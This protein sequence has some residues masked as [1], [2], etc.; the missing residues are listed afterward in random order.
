MLTRLLSFGDVSALAAAPPVPAVVPDL[1]PY[2]QRGQHDLVTQRINVQ[3]QE[4][5]KAVEEMKGSLAQLCAQS[6]WWVSTKM[7]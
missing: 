1:F 5:L 4:F 2:Q 6:R 7:C 3:F